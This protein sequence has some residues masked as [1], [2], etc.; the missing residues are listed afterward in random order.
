[1]ASDEEVWS[2]LKGE[3]SDAATKIQSNFRGYRV[4]KQL[5]R[6][7]AVQVTS[8][9]SQATPSSGSGRE[10]AASAAPPQEKASRGSSE[11]HDMIALSPPVAL[12]STT[13]GE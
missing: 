6:G 9:S 10:S 3:I 7:D 2:A 12:V 4:R 13:E 5:Q 1:M 8:S 11:Y